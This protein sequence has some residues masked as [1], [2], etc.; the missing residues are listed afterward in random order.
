MALY[1]LLSIMYSGG[2]FNR[3]HLWLAARP[4]WPSQPAP[5]TCIGGYAIWQN[6]IQSKSAHYATIPSSESPG[7]EPCRIFR[8]S[9][10]LWRLTQLPQF[11]EQRAQSLTG[12]F[13]KF[14]IYC[15][16]R[17]SMRILRDL[18]PALWQG[19]SPNSFAGRLVKVIMN[20]MGTLKLGNSAAVYYNLGVFGV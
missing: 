6:I 1:N 19:I 4:N 17:Y 5:M 9:S 14:S 2:I 8:W 15:I 10:L 7:R 13:L 3:R 11:H 20:S 18:F 12:R 16:R